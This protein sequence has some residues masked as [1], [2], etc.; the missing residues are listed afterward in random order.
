MRP[1]LTV[2]RN[3]IN[4]FQQYVDILR[5]RVTANTGLGFREVSGLLVAEK[6]HRRPEDLRAFER[7]ASDGMHCFEW[8]VLLD[9][10]EAQWKEFLF[11]LA[12]RAPNDDRLKALA[13]DAP[14]SAGAGGDGPTAE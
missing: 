1:G 10:A 13:C 6:L 4:R 8:R 14:G 9:R 7:M 12:D 3:H 2:D 11:A 5:T